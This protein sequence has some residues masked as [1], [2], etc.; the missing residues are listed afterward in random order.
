MI[1]KPVLFYVVNV[2]WFFLSHRIQLALHALKMGYDVFLITKNTGRKSEIEKQGIKVYDMDFRR[3]GTN[4]ISELKLIFG[5]VKLYRKH[6]PILIHHVTIKP[7]IYGSIAARLS[8]VNPVVVNAVSGLGY[9]FT[10]DR[11]TFF[12]KMLLLL[13][14][15]SFSYHRANFIFQNPDDASFYKSL[16]LIRDGNNILIKGAG[17]DENLFAFEDPIEKEKLIVLLPARMLFDKGINEFYNAAVLL[18][19][20][21]FGKVEF[22][23]A[24]DIDLQNPAGASKE[25]LSSMNIK[26]YFTWVGFQQNIIHLLRTS[27]IICLPSYRE[28]IPKSLIEAMAIG[29]PIVTTDVPG[30]RECVENGVN[31]ILVPPKDFVSLSEALLSLI[32]NPQLRLK[33]GKA[34]RLK[35]FTDMTLGKVVN[36]TFQF[37]KKIQHVA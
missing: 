15:F 33:M 9:N 29:R 7:N 18:K 35:M 1:K 32:N 8:G 14:K 19:D 2:D 16:G 11:K 21:L 22:I 20:K 25:Q 10:D 23:M 4:P 27:D 5:L 6:K 26:G 34:S 28:G 30:C 31:G 3:S 13:I 17:V 36:K 37:Y 24:G 12:Q